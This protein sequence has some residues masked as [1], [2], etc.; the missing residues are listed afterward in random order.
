MNE[1]HINTSY[2]YKIEKAI[3]TMKS[4]NFLIYKINTN[5]NNNL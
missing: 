5:K 2:S 4:R 1:I 3:Q